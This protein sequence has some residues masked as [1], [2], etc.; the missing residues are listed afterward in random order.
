MLY[1]AVC[2]ECLTYIRAEDRA[3][4]SEVDLDC[5]YCEGSIPLLGGAGLAADCNKLQKLLEDIEQ[6]VATL[7]AAID[8]HRFL[9]DQVDYIAQAFNDRLDGIQEQKDDALTN[10]GVQ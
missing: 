6:Q 3:V 7:P 8:V 1:W 2:P 5:P 10:A 9:A 4:S